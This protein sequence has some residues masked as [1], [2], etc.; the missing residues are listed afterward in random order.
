MKYLF[1]KKF[2]RLTCVGFCCFLIT[3]YLSEIKAIAAPQA[4]GPDPTAAFRISVERGDCAFATS[5]ANQVLSRY[6]YGTAEA[7][8]ANLAIGTCL[9]RAKLWS[10]ARR[11]LQRAQP[12]SG[13]SAATRRRLEK[14][15][16]ER[17][18]EEA[19]AVAVATSKTLPP[20]TASRPVWQPPVQFTMPVEPAYGKIQQRSPSVPAKAPKAVVVGSSFSITPELTYKR[21]DTSQ[22]YSALI[23]SNGSALTTENKVTMKAQTSYPMPNVP[24]EALTLSLPVELNLTK[25]TTLGENVDFRRTSDTATTVF[26]KVSDSGTSSNDFI[27]TASPALELPL[28]NAVGLKGSY[29]YSLKSPDFKSK[30]QETT[31]SPKGELTIKTGSVT[32]KTSVA[33]LETLDESGGRKKSDVVY[34]GNASYNVG[35]Q[36]FDVDVSRTETDVP[37]ALRE[38]GVA[39]ANSNASLS[40]KHTSDSGE[41]KLTGT[42]ASFERFPG[43]E[44]KSP[45]MNLKLAGEVTVPFSVFSLGANAAYSSQSD[46]VQGYTIKDESGGDLTIQITAEDTVM[47]FGG[48]FK[49]TAVKWLAI[50]IGYSYKT[51]SYKTNNPLVEKDFLKKNADLTMSTTISASLSREF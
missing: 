1:L 42:Y 40:G 9:L 12:L 11:A 43:I 29:K 51:I 8:Q 2:K 23:Q 38:T 32:S 10:A 7:A 27:T 45:A 3:F 35:A 26:G 44:L 14:Y 19:K 13:R 33:Y 28:M 15:A 30:G 20:P 5:Q 49:V 16:I 37:E 21:I 24:G 31:R 39:A 6:P 41:Y 34:K 48:E 46:F 18:R 25:G 22:N 36:T 4:A 47:E 17:E 50:S